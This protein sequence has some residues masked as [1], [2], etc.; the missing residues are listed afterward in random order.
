[1]RSRILI[2]AAGCLV[3]W[4]LGVVALRWVQ[5][6]APDARSPSRDGVV[7]RLRITSFA[8]G[9][10]VP[11]PS[12]EW[13]SARAAWA[14]YQAFR[15]TN[16]DIALDERETLRLSGAASESA[17]LMSMAGRTA[18]ELIAVNYRVLENWVDQDFLHP[19]DEY[20]L[21]MARENLA[22]PPFVAALPEEDRTAAVRVAA[23]T[24]TLETLRPAWVGVDAAVWET[25]CR[26]GRDGVMHVWAWPS[27]VHTLALYY[28]RYLFAQRAGALLEAGL[29]P[30]RAPRTWEEVIAYSRA[31]T[32][33]NTGNYGL[34]LDLWG[35][36]PYQRHSVAHLTDLL[37]Q[38]GAQVVERDDFNRWRF[39]WDRGRGAV[40]ALR[41]VRELLATR[42][43]NAPVARYRTAGRWNE[44]QTFGSLSRS[45][46]MVFDFS[47]S[48]L[49][50][51]VLSNP[52]TLGIAPLPAGPVVFT[53]PSPALL[54]SVVSREQIPE[55]WEDLRR[56]AREVGRA[57]IVAA[58]ESVETAFRHPTRA[59]WLRLPGARDTPLRSLVNFGDG[60]RIRAAQIDASM[61]GITR[62]TQ[63]PARRAAAWKYIR[64]ISGR[65]ARR[66]RTQLMVESGMT[67]FL[68]PDTLR[69]FG[70]DDLYEAI[71]RAWREAHGQIRRSGRPSPD[72]AN[73][74]YVHQALARM[75][76]SLLILSPAAQ[77]ARLAADT[78]IA[79]AWRGGE[80]GPAG[81]L[82]RVDA[83]TLAEFA[84]ESRDYAERRLLNR[85]PPDQQR[86]TE[87]W[88]MAVVVVLAIG[89]PMALYAVV[90]NRPRLPGTVGAVNSD[91]IPLRAPR[92]A[93][94]KAWAFMALAIGS[95]LV[96]QYYP[97]ARGAT[98]A[99][100]EY[101]IMSADGG[102]TEWVGLRN[103]AQ[104]FTEPTARTAALNTLLFVSLSLGIGFVLPIGL[105]IMLSEI[106]RGT[107]LLRVLY[108][109]P[110]AMGGLIVAYL[111]TWLFDPQP[112][113][114]LN[115]AVAPLLPMVNAVGAWS[116]ERRGVLVAT[117]LAAVATAVLG[118][119]RAAVTATATLAAI[120]VGVALL[121]S[122]V[123]PVTGPI[124]WLSSS[125]LL[126][127]VCVIIPG[128]W[129][130]L[131]P[132]CIIYLAAL[133][134]IPEE[135]YE[136][137]DLDGAGAW[138]KIRH[139]VLPFLKPLIVIQFVGAVI[140]AFR[141][142]EG[143]FVMTGGGPK[144]GTLVVGMEVWYNAFAYLRFGYATAMAWVLGACLIGFTVLQ[145][146]ILRH[147][148]FTT[149]AAPRGSGNAGGGG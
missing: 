57:D 118:R 126:A 65:E 105:A 75:V 50:V 82:E 32:D 97:L 99:F 88:A 5:V 34:L 117:L 127:M 39:V 143:I 35:V 102:A 149:A 72:G 122:A 81:S 66:I 111:W 119:R 148:R 95:I 3:A 37:W 83:A 25:I 146:R 56:V 48:F 30:N 136:A 55:N 8:G 79:S 110:A 128:V 70:H 147:A 68:N 76:D 1:M 12:D 54:A 120:T 71:P 144:D 45:P 28:N 13:P 104:L 62:L 6:K 20:V 49:A 132:G 123:A 141:N 2:L 61:F 108:Y 94:L 129:A 26:P 134:A 89:F 43:G 142:W 92:G 73:C 124:R 59:G 101:R 137:A 115:R 87:R 93:Y 77:Q 133:R 116:S 29:D 74:Q 90:R 40:D 47:S 121:A 44:E 103:F 69:E 42:V 125:P 60:W 46:A 36:D 112:T 53:E 114:W 22:H 96:W 139:V 23:D 4:S 63:H 31:L 138:Q 113:G 107:M 109:L 135:V 7:H 80:D 145:L 106:P 14:V 27:D 33:P 15:R 91:D 10:D 51:K 78:T 9:G 18:G 140:A 85:M 16:P 17:I 52:E 21:A 100:Q 64:Y 86:R 19:L 58:M 130:G 131:G 67:A 24:L 84:H 38:A 11:Q 98:M 41:Y